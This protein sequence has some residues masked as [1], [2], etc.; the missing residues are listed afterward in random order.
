MTLSIMAATEAVHEML[1]K[2][3]NGTTDS[4]VTMEKFVF[5]YAVY[6]RKILNV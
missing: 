4:V 1:F 3:Q 6:Q 2:Y 5:V